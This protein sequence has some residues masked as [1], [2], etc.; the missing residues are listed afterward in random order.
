LVTWVH[1]A[2][3]TGGATNCKEDDIVKQT[4]QRLG[5][6]IVLMASLL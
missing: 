3:F 4:R 5:I 6:G 2:C 1:W